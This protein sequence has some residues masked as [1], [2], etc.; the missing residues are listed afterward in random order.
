MITTAIPGR[1][2]L[3]IKVLLLDLNGTLTFD[4]CIIDGVTERITQLKEKV[5]IFILTAD[6]FGLGQQVAD[7]LKVECVKVSPEDGNQDKTCFL[8][9]YKP[10][11]VAAVGNG[12]NDR[13]MLAEAGLS[14]VVIGPE[15]CSPQ[16]LLGA[17]IA[18]A[19]INDALDLLLNPMRI[20]ATLRA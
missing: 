9:R 16:A 15:G 13:G 6:T 14:I 1:P 7:G 17:D 8:H 12:F 2:K 10:E 5:D 4:G 19:D 3:E 18:V 20:K 11:N